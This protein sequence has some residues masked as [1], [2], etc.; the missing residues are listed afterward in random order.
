MKLSIRQRNKIPPLPGIYKLY[1]SSNILLYVGKAKNLKKRVFSYFDTQL[2]E[3]KIR[4]MINQIKYIEVI[5]VTSE[6]EA[7]LLEAKLIRDCQPKYNS[8]GKDGKN[9]IYIKI[10]NEKFPKIYFSRKVDH[11]GE[12]FGPFPSFQIV[13]EIL[14]YIRSIFPYCTQ[15]E[16]IRRS[17]FYHHIGLCNPCPSD[18]IKLTGMEY[19]LLT[20]DY[21]QNI[22]NIK[23]ILNGNI[24]I[25]NRMLI[26]K[27]KVLSKQ[28][29]Y[30]K[31]SI[32][33]DKLDKLNYL[34]HQ[35]SPIESYIKNPKFLYNLRNRERLDL[36]KILSSYYPKISK[37]H[38][39]EC[40]DISNTS[41]KLATGSLVTFKD[42]EPDKNLYRKFRIRSKNT[43]DDFGMLQEMISRRLKHKEWILPDLFVIDGGA[44]QLLVLKKVF[45]QL[46]IEIPI[47]GLAKEYESIV[48]P[49]NNSYIKI[50]LEA[51]SMALNLIKRLRDEAHRFAHSYHTLLRLKYL[52]G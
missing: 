5:P 19:K 3:P 46:N 39:I 27:M 16:S 6:F 25:L 50:E 30:E 21:L 29:D 12:Y 43:P 18:I 52:L 45:Y 23:N 37:V 31:A 22:R 47:I 14:S 34:V 20:K 33:R 8:I 9:Y 11:T 40:Y 36:E 44:L 42:G 38:Y 10:S 35:Y 17:C 28:E 7:L 4:L 15:K 26:A 51:N 48:I 41:G 32:W 49:I 2:K 1:S 13:K 24:D